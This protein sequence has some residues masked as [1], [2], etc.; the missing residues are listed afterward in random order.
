MVLNETLDNILDMQG[1][2]GYISGNYNQ[3][4]KSVKII[5]DTG[6]EYTFNLSCV[7]YIKNDNEIVMFDINEMPALFLKF[8][9]SEEAKKFHFKIETEKYKPNIVI[10]FDRLKDIRDPN[11]DSPY[12]YKRAIYIQKNNRFMVE[13]E[14]DDGIFTGNRFIGGFSIVEKNHNSIKLKKDTHPSQDILSIHDENLD[15]IY[16]I[17]MDEFYNIASKKS[18][19]RKSK[20]KKSKKRKS[21]RITKRRSKKK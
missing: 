18:K 14:D 6:Q 1:G 13:Y 8:H 20:R 15:E 5:Y 11:S 21:K 10:I 7:K 9:G 12:S 4:N 3:D 16:K 19:K 2:R 17:I